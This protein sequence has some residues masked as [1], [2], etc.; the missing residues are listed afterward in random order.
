M[1]AVVGLALSA[2]GAA[3]LLP[4]QSEAVLLALLQQQQHSVVLLLCV[5]SMA[6]ILGSCVNWWLGIHMQRYQQRSWFP[7]SPAKL[8]RAQVFYQRY[9]Y[10]SLLLSW[11][12]IIGDP[13]TLMAGVMRC[14]FLTFVLVVSLAKIGRYLCVYWLYLQL[15]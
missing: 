4:L 11:L 15:I 13:L 6:N 3:T 10:Y 12:P 8:Q 9:G 7:V 2:F 14:R 1:W 5:A